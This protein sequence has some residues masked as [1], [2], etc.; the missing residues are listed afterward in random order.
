[1]ASAKKSITDSVES[2]QPEAASILNRLGSEHVVCLHRLFTKTALVS[3]FETNE[4]FIPRSAR[5]KFELTSSK[6]AKPQK[7]EYESICKDTE[8]Q[9]LA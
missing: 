8:T 9:S 7:E 4:K 5:I 3:K 6:L 2:L 1:M